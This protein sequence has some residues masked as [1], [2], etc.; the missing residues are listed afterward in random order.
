M[1]NLKLR[2]DQDLPFPNFRTDNWD[3]PESEDP[4]EKLLSKG[5]SND[6][7]ADAKTRFETRRFKQ[8]D[9]GRSFLEQLDAL[10]ASAQ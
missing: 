3:L 4:N 5:W 1:G 6:Q 9:M 2:G 10:S 8:A 7:K